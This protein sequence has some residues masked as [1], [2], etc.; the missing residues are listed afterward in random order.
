[1]M[2]NMDQQGVKRAAKGK[3]ALE[4]RFLNHWRLL[5]PTLPAPT[6]QYEF[7]RPFRKWRFDFSWIDL[8]LAVEIQGGSFMGGKG[9]GHNRGAQQANDYEKQN[10]AVQLGWR[11]LH[12][13][14]K[15]MDD[16]VAVVEFVAGVLTNAKEVTTG[17]NR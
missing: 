12:F 5:F 13:N 16:A 17:E 3:A 4:Q 8:K 11:V 2:E 7:H 6:L 10:T 15:Q 1:M 14:T 9:G